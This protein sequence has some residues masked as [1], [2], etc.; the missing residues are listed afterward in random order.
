[1]PILKVKV[2]QPASTDMTLAVSKTLLEL[3]TRILHKKLGLTSIAID[4]VPP[5]HQAVGGSTLAVQ[6]KSSFLFRHPG[7]G[8]HPHRRSK[9]AVHCRSVYCFSKLLGKPHEESYICVHD[10]RAEAYGFGRLAQAY[11][12]IEASA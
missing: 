10:V 2:S 4:Y 8:W 1:M 11:R 5:E 12:D 6:D 7:R 9:G 3:T